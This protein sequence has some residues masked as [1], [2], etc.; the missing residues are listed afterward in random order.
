MLFRSHPNQWEL[1]ICREQ[2]L[3]AQGL[4][5]AVD[6]WYAGDNGPRSAMAKSAPA[7]CSS[8]GFLIP[9]GG[10]LGQAFGV[11]ANEYG[12]ADG[13]IVAMNFG[14]GAHSSVK[15]ETRDLVPVVRLVVDD[16]SDDLAQAAEINEIDDDFDQNPDA[17]LVQFE[18]DQ[19]SQNAAIIDAIEAFDEEL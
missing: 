10:S 3:S 2:I 6:R 13:Q 17:D 9:I 4:D 14:C 5:L 15:V 11:C 16:V 8:C 19:E 12:A 7:N 1:G 18:A